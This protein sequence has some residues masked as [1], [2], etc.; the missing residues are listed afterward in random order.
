MEIGSH[1]SK[2]PR[3]VSNR[4][5][6]PGSQGDGGAPI[7]PIAG[8]VGRACAFSQL[9]GRVRLPRQQLTL[10][11]EKSLLVAAKRGAPV[12][13]GVGVVT[14]PGPHFD[15]RS[16]RLIASPGQGTQD[17]GLA[18]IDDS[19]FVAG[20]GAEAGPVNFDFGDLPETANIAANRKKELAH[21]LLG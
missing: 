17:E 4:A 20:K 6:G 7:A 5:L 15:A 8:I 13:V 14:Q 1:L 9:Q 10:A 18:Y 2:A 12:Q 21:R 11:I 19:G 3:P 16:Q